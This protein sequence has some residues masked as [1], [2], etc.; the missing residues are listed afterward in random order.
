MRVDVAKIE[1]IKGLGKTD[2]ILNAVAAK[3]SFKLLFWVFSWN[4]FTAELFL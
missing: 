3:L 4:L 1:A 2:F